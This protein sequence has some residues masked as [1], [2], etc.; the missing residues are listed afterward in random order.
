MYNKNSGCWQQKN[1]KEKI[2][3][4]IIKSTL[5]LALVGIVPFGL[6]MVFGPWMFGFVFGAEWVQTGVYAQW[7]T[8]WLFAGFINVPSNKALPILSLLPFFL[9][10]EVSSII[11][12]LAVLA[13]GFY[14]FASDTVAIALFSVVGAILNI[15]LISISINKARHVDNIS[16]SL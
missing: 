4:L 11:L 14:V 10:Y 12:R 7:I 13:V 15:A 2:A 8:F 16:S 1:N 5:A 6:V 3:P 9:V